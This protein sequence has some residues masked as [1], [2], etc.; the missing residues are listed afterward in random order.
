MG[1]LMKTDIHTMTREERLEFMLA[2]GLPED[3]ARRWNKMLW[4]FPEDG[5]IPPLTDKD[6]EWA[7]AVVKRWFERRSDEDELD[8]RKRV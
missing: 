2:E 8:T 3:K 7:D 4:C 1:E 5:P 6:K